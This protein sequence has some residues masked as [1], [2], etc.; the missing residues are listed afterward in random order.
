MAVVLLA[1]LSAA[2][3]AQDWP[4][5]R[6]PA[7]T[8]AVQGFK[9][10]ATWPD[11]PKQVWKVQVGSGHS[12]PIVAGGRVYLFTR[13]G[14]QEVVSARELANG[15]EVWR[16]AY[17]APYQMNPAASAHGKGPKS[18]PV[19][20]GGRIFTFGISG[21]LTGWQAQDGR[22]LW[23][24]DFRKEFPSTVPEFGVA[25]SPAVV[26]GLLIVHAGG[27]GN[28]AVMALDPASGATKWAWKGD[29][30]AYDSPIVAT[31]AATPQIVLQSQ[32]NLV[33]LGL[34]GRREHRRVERLR[35]QE[36][37]RRE[38]AYHAK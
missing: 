1:M 2:V 35:G 24:R 32:R 3:V 14:E 10:P 16:Q 38:A 7:R 22:R 29:G 19:H 18:T 6:G 31:F 28:G 34:D 37:S 25:M 36:R 9:P 13:A 26:N 4:Q 15:R 21:I 5:W 17:E 23:T 8:G 12:S 27:A 33:S 30:P 20:D 11:R